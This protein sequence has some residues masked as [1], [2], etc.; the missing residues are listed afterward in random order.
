MTGNH[1]RRPDLVEHRF[2]ADGPDRLWV[3]DITYAST[4]VEFLYLAVV[5][6]ELRHWGSIVR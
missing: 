5:L 2:N 6:P 1:T 4:A 3:T